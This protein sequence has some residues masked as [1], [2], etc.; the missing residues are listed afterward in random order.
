VVL[1]N[2]HEPTKIPLDYIAEMVYDFA[3]KHDV[4]PLSGKRRSSDP[5]DPHPIKK[6]KHIN[7]NRER[8]KK[9][10]MDDWLG[11]I[12]RYPDKSFEHTF[13]IK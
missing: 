1:S 13:C 11:P 4:Q 9:S 8:A 12:P 5:D 6:R 10:V 7:Y 3:R 2:R